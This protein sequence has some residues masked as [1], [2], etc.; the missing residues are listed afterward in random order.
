MHFEWGR[1]F[2]SIWYN[3][4][5][6]GDATIVTNYMT[7]S[8]MGLVNYLGIMIPHFVSAANI[9]LMRQNF[10]TIP[11]EPEIA[12]DIDGCS[13]FGSTGAFYRLLQSP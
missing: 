4:A 7:V 8:G 13:A 10:K 6:P 5:I 1:T 2:C 12:A 3:H 9:F 11:K